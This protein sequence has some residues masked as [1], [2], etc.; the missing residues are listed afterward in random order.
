MN[1]IE[2]IK[3]KR[4][5]K[6]I[7]MLQKVKIANKKAFFENNADLQ[8]HIKSKTYHFYYTNLKDFKHNIITKLNDF[9]LIYLRDFD[10][11]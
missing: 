5:F 1:I 10:I 7:E 2:A 4:F 11:N 9:R 6:K 3:L 8:L